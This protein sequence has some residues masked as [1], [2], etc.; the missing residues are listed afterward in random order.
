[1]DRLYITGGEYST[2][3]TPEGALYYST[4]RVQHRALSSLARAMPWLGKPCRTGKTGGKD[5]E[6]KKQAG[7]RTNGRGGNS[8]AQPYRRRFIYNLYV[9]LWMREELEG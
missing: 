1:M 6:V 7:E 9:D 4:P 2:G 3:D 8:Y 5:K